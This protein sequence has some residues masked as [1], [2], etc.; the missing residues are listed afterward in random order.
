MSQSSAAPGWRVLTRLHQRWSEILFVLLAVA[1][2]AWVTDDAF[3]SRIVTVSQGADYWE[4]SATLR[5]LL[6]DPWHPKNPHL[7]SPASSPRFVPPFI[8]AALIARAFGL[9]ALGAMGVASCLNMSLLLAGIFVFFRAYF[10]DP[11]ASLY[12][13][14]VMF[15]SWSDGWNFSNVYQLKILF[16]VASYPSTAALG[17]CLLGF[18]ITLR[19]LREP[20][21]RIWLG[22]TAAIWALVMITH[23]LTAMLG[24]AGAMLLAG[25]SPGVPFRLRAKVVAA[26]VLGGVLSLLWP[27]FSVRATLSGGGHDNV[28]AITRGLTGE[29]SL[30]RSGR[31]H[32]FYRQDA[33]VR[34]LGVALAGLPISLYLIARRKHWFISLGA[35]AMLLPF[36]VNAYVP[37]P[38]GHRFIL[39]A[40]FFL[41]MAVVWLLL[42]VS[43]GAPE[44]WPALTV[45]FRGWIAGALIALLF[46]AMS[47]SNIQA[48]EG[49][50]AY[51]HRKMRAA[52]SSNVRY[53]RRL[54]EL[55]G[56]AAVVMADVRT[57]WPV[58]TFGP[59]VLALWH[60]NPLVPDEDERKAAVARFFR[61]G[62]PDDTRLEIIAK[63]GVTHVL[64]RGA[65][66]RRLEPFLAPRA[67]RRSLPAG[68]ALYALHSNDAGR[69]R[70]R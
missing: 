39:L 13:L 40:V 59:K 50:M 31:L 61:A 8:L 58:P 66:S 69:S 5:A 47:W 44:S 18:T 19:A 20:H 54:A 55:S 22:F 3:T 64:A 23:P 42:K 28:V 12:G 70:P 62:T 49:H 52:E 24:F 56:P 38:L 15:T 48:A 41:Q 14:V 29:A 7:V 25:T 2:L 43:R 26:I 46:V 51:S 17:M 36:V 4:H 63:Y 68:Y 11:R 32:E 60:P 6:D 67:R 35:V 45:G 53:A 30:E 21:R 10:H 33:L 37:L 9:D 34:A 1:L 16:S 57:S 27:Y 65:V